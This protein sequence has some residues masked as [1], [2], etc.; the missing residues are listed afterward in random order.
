MRYEQTRF[1]VKRTPVVYM[2]PST[3]IKGETM[4]KAA[5]VGSVAHD[6]RDIAPWSGLYDPFAALI[7]RY[8]F[9]VRYAR[10]INEF[11]FWRSNN[12]A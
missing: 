5:L 9:A 2:L 11:P 3:S 4:A 1:P 12:Y 8:I 7:A 6:Y 10:L